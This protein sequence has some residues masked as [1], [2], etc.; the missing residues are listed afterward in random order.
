[1]SGARPSSLAEVLAAEYN[2]IPGV[3]SLQKHDVTEVVK[4]L[5][6]AN[7]QECVLYR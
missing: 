4:T 6:H 5:A 2:V 3:P 1:M 7:T